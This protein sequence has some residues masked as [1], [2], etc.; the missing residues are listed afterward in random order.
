[1]KIFAEK[2]AYIK[3]FSAAIPVK[4]AHENIVRTHSRTPLSLFISHSLL[5]V[6]LC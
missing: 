1:M 3:S 4:T 5:P 6:R 2:K